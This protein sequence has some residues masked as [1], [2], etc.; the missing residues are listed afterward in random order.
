MAVVRSTVVRH[1]LPIITFCPVNGLPDVIYISVEFTEFT[2][3]YEAR[4]KIRKAT[5]WRK[6]FMETIADDILKLFPQANKITVQL[7]FGRHVVKIYPRA[8]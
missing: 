5:M 4:K 7:A 8:I 1:W 3:L 6:A 2:E